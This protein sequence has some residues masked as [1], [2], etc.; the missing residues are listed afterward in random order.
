VVRDHIGQPVFQ[1]IITLGQARVFMVRLAGFE[2]VIVPDR[3]LVLVNR[4]LR[5]D[6]L[7]AVDFGLYTLDEVFF[8]LR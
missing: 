3:T 2:V 6:S 1:F 7:A 8:F 5:N 4:S